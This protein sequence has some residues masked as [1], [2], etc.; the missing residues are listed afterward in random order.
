MAIPSAVN[1]LWEVKFNMKLENQVCNNILHFK[2]V[3]ATADTELNLIIVLAACFITHLLPVLANDLTLESL[4]WKKVTPVLG[5]ENTTIPTGTLVGGVDADSL[6]SFVS[7]V[8]SKQTLTGGRSHRGRM[9]IP[10]IP[11]NMT[12]KSNILTESDLW[13]GI[14]AFITCV[15]TNFKHPD[16]GGGTDIFDLIVYSRKIGG[17]AFPY[18][19]TGVTDVDNLVPHVALGTT[20]SRKVGRGS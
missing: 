15:L 17:S 13:E 16:P 10:G 5:V 12:A 1:D 18:G 3:G 9:Y 4:T 7:A 19:L 20:R 6:P 2:C 11:E 14:A 8:I